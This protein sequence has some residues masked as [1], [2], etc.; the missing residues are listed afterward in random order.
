VFDAGFLSIGVAGDPRA[1]EYFAAVGEGLSSGYVSGPNL[2][3]FYYK[4]CQKLGKQ[5][6]DAW[7]YRAVESGLSVVHGEELDRLAGAEKCSHS[8]ELSLA[9][10][11]ALALAKREGALLLTTDGALARTSGVRTRHFVP[12]PPDEER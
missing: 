12:R 10:C 9:D 7:Y 4:T 6:A 5:T 2:A 8:S 1:R 3:E 11:F